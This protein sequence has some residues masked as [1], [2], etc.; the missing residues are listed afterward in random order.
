MTGHGM[1]SCV[2]IP[3]VRDPDRSLPSLRWRQYGTLKP[4][5]SVVHLYGAII[6]K[7]Y[8]CYNSGV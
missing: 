4:W 5:Q 2:L 8:P 6:Q 3:H 7:Q 1:D